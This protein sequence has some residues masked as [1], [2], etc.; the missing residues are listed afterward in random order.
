MKYED[1]IEELL[2]LSVE[3][4]VIIADSFLKSLNAM[5]SEVD[6]KWAAV[7][8]RQLME[9]HFGNTK[10]APTEEIIPKMGFFKT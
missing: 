6:Q 9:L 10:G 2:S 8:K 3:D 4:R 1:L 7:A 5:Q